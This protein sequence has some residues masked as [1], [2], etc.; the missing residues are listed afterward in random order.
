[1]REILLFSASWCQPCKT[2]KAFAADIPTVRIVDIE[3]DPNLAATYMVRGVPTLVKL[4]DGEAIDV[5]NGASMSE[6]VFKEW[7]NN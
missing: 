6:R 1:M 4:I 5:R 7:V 2:L 3:D